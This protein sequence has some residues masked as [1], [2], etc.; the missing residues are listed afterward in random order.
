MRF[1][2]RVLLLVVAAAA[3][4]AAAPCG[5][6]AA[7]DGAQAAAPVTAQE[8]KKLRDGFVAKLTQFARECRTKRCLLESREAY[9]RIVGLDPE[10]AEARKSLF[11]EKK[12]GRWYEPT[13]AALPASPEKVV[14]EMKA[15]GKGIVEPFVARALEIVAAPGTPQTLREQV[16]EDV[17]AADPSNPAAR[18]ANREVDDQG[19]WRLE[20]TVAARTRRAELDT[21]FRTRFD[22]TKA[23]APEPATAGEIDVLGAGALATSSYFGRVSGSASNPE[24]AD[25]ARLQPGLEALYRKAVGPPRS[26]RNLKVLLF[27]DGASGVAAVRRDSRFPNDA[28]DLAERLGATWAP[29]TLDY[30]CYGQTPEGRREMAMRAVVGTWLFWAYGVDAKKGWALEGFNHWFSEMTLGTHRVCYFRPSEYAQDGV[31]QALTDKLR[32]DGANWMALAAELTSSDAFP[33][34]RSILAKD[35]NSLGP[36][37]LLTAYT[38]SRYV[39]EAHPKAIEDVLRAVTAGEAPDQWF[40]R[41]LGSTPEGLDRRLRRW[42]AE[43]VATAPAAPPAAP[44]PPAPQPPKAPQPPAPQPPKK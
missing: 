17:A 4:P 40:V 30:F 41:L 25:V 19:A 27:P 23:P 5:A 44:Q 3:G 8:W 28:Q 37:G 1:T 2:R 6:L 33:G 29:G 24:I 18:R 16:A 39:I 31:L 36:D 22:A 12:G 13:P 26:I 38:L 20:E 21:I 32:A 42:T 10:N 43:V 9:Q 34:V 7:P 35:V 14:D 11:H 15:E